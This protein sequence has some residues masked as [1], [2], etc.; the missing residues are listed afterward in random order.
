VKIIRHASCLFAATAFSAIFIH[1]VSAHETAQAVLAP[2]SAPAEQPGE[3]EQLMEHTQIGESLFP[4]GDTKKGGQGQ[5]VDG[6]AGLGEEMLKVHTHSHLS[7]FYKGKRIAIPPGIG[8]IKPYKEVSHPFYVE[9]ATGFYS[10]HTHDATGI[11]HVES[12]DDRV[13]TLGNF[14]NVW[15]RPLTR[16]NVAGLKGPVQVFVDGK[17]YT[18]SIRDIVLNP[19]TLITLE[20][21]EPIVKPPVY[22]FPEGM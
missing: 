19:H 17:A 11:I 18:G 13:F 8:I 20:V 5:T 22:R 3:I 10:L 12:P 1:S 9:D 15:G 6:I 2:A 16:N 21:G 7:L 4:D 14:F